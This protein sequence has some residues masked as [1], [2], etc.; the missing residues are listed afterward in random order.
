VESRGA[1]KAQPGAPARSGLRD[2]IDRSDEQ[3]L[4]DKRMQRVIGQ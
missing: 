2:L 1:A 3:N 4:A